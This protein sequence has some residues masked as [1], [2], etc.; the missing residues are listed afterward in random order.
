V[1]PNWTMNYWNCV[2]G[3]GSQDRPDQQNTRWGEAPQR[4]SADGSSTD[5]CRRGHSTA[6]KS[7]ADGDIALHGRVDGAGWM[8]F[9]FLQ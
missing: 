3:V 9:N 5:G 8:N 6:R 1:S 4:S 2:R 7:S